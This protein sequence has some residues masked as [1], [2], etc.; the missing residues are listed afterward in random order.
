MLIEP[1][2]TES[3]AE[4]DRF[5]DAMIAIAERAKGNDVEAFK[6]APRLTPVRRLDETRAA[7]QPKLR[8]TAE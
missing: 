3:K 2:E 1:T 7:R 4:L 5:A 8:W 6:Q